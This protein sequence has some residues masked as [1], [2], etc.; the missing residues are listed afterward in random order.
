LCKIRKAFAKIPIRRI[1]PLTFDSLI[2]ATQSEASHTGRI[3]FLIIF[4]RGADIHARAET[5]KSLSSTYAEHTKT[6]AVRMCAAFVFGGGVVY[7]ALL[8]S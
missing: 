3:V 5:A 7:A 8:F 6:K 1:Y 4:E 2:K